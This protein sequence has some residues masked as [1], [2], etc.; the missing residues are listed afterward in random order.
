[1]PLYQ[2]KK[3]DYTPI[4]GWSLSRYDIFQTCKRRYYYTYYSKFDNEYS[5]DKIL[6]LREMISAP[7]AVGNVAHEMI[8]TLLRR[9]LKD[10]GTIRRNKFFNY[11][12]RTLKEYCK[13]NTFRETYYKEASKIDILAIEDDVKLCLNNFLDSNRVT[14]LTGRA[15]KTK[16]DWILDPPGYGES[17]IDDLKVY[18][19]V[20]F[21]FP[22]DDSIY[23]IDWKTGKPLEQKHYK[24]LLGYTSWASYHLNIAPDK[25][26]PVVAYLKPEYEEKEYE[27][28]EDD[29]K[30]FFSSIKGETSEMYEYCSDIEENIPKQKASFIKTDNDKI[31]ENCNFRELCFN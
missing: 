28:T 3:F 9:L 4:L 8:K 26:I 12:F 31:C 16:K 17:R 18:S 27:F 23:I 13:N 5:T 10:E 20:D 22:A 19:K 11:T 24:Q 30:V 14:W 6:F 15:I 2:I 29:M 7:L 25:I 21:L 1:M